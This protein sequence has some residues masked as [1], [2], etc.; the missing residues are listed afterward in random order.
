MLLANDGPS[1]AAELSNC[2]AGSEE[3]SRLSKEC[4]EVAV[5]VLFVYFSAYFF[6]VRVFSCVALIIVKIL[7][8]QLL[9]SD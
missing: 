6:F 3:V 5:V 2:D 4:A 9:S 7:L 8:L 1:L